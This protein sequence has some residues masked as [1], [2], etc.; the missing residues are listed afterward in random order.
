MYKK[1][2]FIMCERLSEA[3]D[4]YKTFSTRTDRDQASKD[5]LDLA[6]RT[7]NWGKLAGIIDVSE[8]D[9]WNLDQKITRL[10]SA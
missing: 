5:L 9:S 2:F 3:Y 10:L 1:E 6:R 4:T 7:A 8:I